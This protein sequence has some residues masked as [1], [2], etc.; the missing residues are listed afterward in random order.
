MCTGCDLLLASINSNNLGC[1]F[2]IDTWKIWSYDGT[3]K[4]LIESK[5]RRTVSGSRAEY[6]HFIRNCFKKKCENTLSK[7]P[8]TES[9][10]VF[11]CDVRRIKSWKISQK[12][13]VGIQLHYYVV[14]G[15]WSICLQGSAYLTY[16]YY[17]SVKVQIAS[18]YSMSTYLLYKFYYSLFFQIFKAWFTIQFRAF[19]MRLYWFLPN[20]YEKNSTN[21]SKLEWIIK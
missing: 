8:L 21:I 14:I 10:S 18:K 12:E 1:I 15:N 4:F 20:V 9:Y 17:P 6:H 16:L 5:L 11:L 3:E 7:R 2:K 13:P 19:I